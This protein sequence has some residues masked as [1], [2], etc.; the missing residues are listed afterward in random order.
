MASRAEII[1]QQ[2][3]DGVRVP[4]TPHVPLPGQVTFSQMVQPN[5]WGIDPADYTDITER[6]V[7]RASPEYFGSAL[8]DLDWR[9]HSHVVDGIA[10]NTIE[11][12]G[13]PHSPQVE[14]YGEPAADRAAEKYAITGSLEKQRAKSEEHS[15]RSL[16]GLL[17]ST[18]MLRDQRVAEGATL[19]RI[20]EAAQHPG[21]ARRKEADTWQA[22]VNT[23]YIV[24]ENILHVVGMQRGWTD[25]QAGLAA[26]SLNYRLLMQRQH[27]A[28]IGNWRGMLD[29]AI[30]YNRARLH[31]CTDRAQRLERHI[32]AAAV[33]TR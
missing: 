27:N 9:T 15:A 6:M 33:K 13:I 3:L 25:E 4:L 23:R 19:A 5:V 31:L 21:L 14:R 12:R 32:G 26:R 20:R 16:E 11:Y 17:A 30:A 7:E 18:Q 10:L 1:G 2:A 29:L 28:H 8:L 22:L 24:F